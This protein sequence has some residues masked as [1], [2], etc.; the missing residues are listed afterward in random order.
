MM[1]FPSTESEDASSKNECGFFPL[2]IQSAPGLARPENTLLTKC[3]T[4]FFVKNTIH[5]VT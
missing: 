3:V 5:G 1:D 4:V 2:L